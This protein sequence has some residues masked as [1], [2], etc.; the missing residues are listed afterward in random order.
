MTVVWFNKFD[1]AEI[2]S[3]IIEHLKQYPADTLEHCKE[4]NKKD[5]KKYYGM[6]IL[7]FYKCNKNGHPC[8]VVLKGYK[9]YLSKLTTD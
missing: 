1:A 2:K 3:K 8:R 5:I 7:N 6:E 9:E 4:Y